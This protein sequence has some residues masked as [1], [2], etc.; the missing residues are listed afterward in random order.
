MQF[1]VV[2]DLNLL[3]LNLTERTPGSRVLKPDQHV[4]VCFQ[5]FAILI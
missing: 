3:P 1:F 5:D 2:C 4:C